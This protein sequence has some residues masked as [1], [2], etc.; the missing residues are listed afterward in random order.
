[1]IVHEDLRIAHLIRRPRPRPAPDGAYEA[2]GAAAKAGLNRSIHDA[3]WAQLLA[4]IAYKA[5]DAGRQAIAVDARHTSQRCASCGHVAADSRVT[6]AQFCCVACG[7]VAHADVNAARNILRLGRSQQP[8]TAQGRNWPITH[9]A[10][11]LPRGRR[12]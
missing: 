12:L 9:P 2:N 7:H 1:M 10:V 4:M 5:E 11:R 6:Q 8:Q 3:G